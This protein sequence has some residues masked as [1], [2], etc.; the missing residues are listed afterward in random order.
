MAQFPFIKRFRPPALFQT[1]SAVGGK[2][3][4]TVIM[5][6]TNDSNRSSV[7]R[8]L[9]QRDSSSSFSRE[10]CIGPLTPDRLFPRCS[11]QSGTGCHEGGG[12]G[13]CKNKEK[14]RVNDGVETLLPKIRFHSFELEFLF[15]LLCALL[16]STEKKKEVEPRG[17]RIGTHMATFE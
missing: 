12:G 11:M 14:K 17:G 3:L 8:S 13:G 9:E 10:R 4:I 5:S 2:N 15:F 1:R 7:T 16:G 6:T